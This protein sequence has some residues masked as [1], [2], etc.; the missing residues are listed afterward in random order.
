MNLNL[1]GVNWAA[2]AVAGLA[3]FFLG[4]LWYSALF[5]KAWTRLHGFTPEKIAQMMARRPVAVF[6]A[7]MIACYLVL[8]AAVAVLVA[9]FNV[10]GAGGGVLL[11]IILWIGPAASIGL[12]GQI[13]SDRHFGIFFID[14]G[15]QFVCLTA[16]GAIVGAWR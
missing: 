16:I 6:F 13:A 5:G 4:G 12:T 2:A 9:S 8:A 14:T 7:W 3:A 10:T 1:A 11:G 15:F